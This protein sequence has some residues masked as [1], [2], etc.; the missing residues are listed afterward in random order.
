MK[1]LVYKTD[2]KGRSAG[3]IQGI[4]EEVPK[5]SLISNDICEILDVPAELE[6]LDL[7]YLETKWIEAVEGVP[8]QPEYWSNGETMYYNA[9]DIPVV[10]DEDGNVTV[11][12]SYIY[13]AEVQAVEAVE[14]HYIIQKKQGAD[15]E[16]SRKN[17][18]QIVRQAIAFGQNLLVEFSS[19]NIIMGITQDGMTKQVR[20]AMSEI[21]LAIQTGS[22]YDAIDEIDLIPAEAKDG[23]YITDARLQEYKTKIQNYL[24]A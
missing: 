15:Q 5:T 3:D 20:Q 4:Y 22:L 24:G 13:Y 7:Q 8:Y 14:A 19:E 6:S 16:M 12:P 1:A 11:D 9:E 23:K 2:Y 18:E 21:I 17:V 10:T